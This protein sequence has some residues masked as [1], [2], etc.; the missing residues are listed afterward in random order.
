MK[1][2][3]FSIHDVKAGAFL[4]P[5]ILPRSEMAARVFSDCINSEDH[6]FGKHPEDY[7]LFRLGWF[8]DEL[9]EY[10]LEPA[11]ISEGNGVTYL[12]LEATAGL[13]AHGYN[14]G[15]ETKIGDEAPILTGAK[16]GNPT[17]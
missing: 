11:P 6:Q 13:T 8:D 12:N 15:Q 10:K 17:E 3:V 9:A 2:L 4:P 14:S 7:T 16:G 1:H 5:F